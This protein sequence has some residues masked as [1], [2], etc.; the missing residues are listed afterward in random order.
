MAVAN[1][2]LNGV[3]A[4]KC[5]SALKRQP[6]RPVDASVGCLPAHIGQLR[7]MRRPPCGLKGDNAQ[8][9]ELR[10][11]PPNPC[12]V[13]DGRSGGQSIRCRKTPGTVGTAFYRAR[14][15]CVVIRKIALCC[16]RTKIK[17]RIRIRIRTR[18]RTRTRTKPAQASTRGRTH[19]HQTDFRFL[20]GRGVLWRAS[21]PRR[22]SAA[23]QI[24]EPARRYA[25]GTREAQE[26]TSEFK[27]Y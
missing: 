26:R 15:Y 22:S 4:A 5:S 1:G 7:S 21:M 3:A 16:C 25:R 12:R 8:P 11:K 13:S 18:T 6:P 27:T 2:L 24:G 10:L 23:T 19:Q 14:K 17:T 9:S 20:E